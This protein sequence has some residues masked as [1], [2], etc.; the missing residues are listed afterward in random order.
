[1]A[2]TLA[3]LCMHYVI[4]KHSWRM[5]F[6]ASATRQM[7]QM[8]LS[9]RSMFISAGLSIL[10]MTTFIPDRG[11]STVCLRCFCRWFLTWKLISWK[12]ST[13]MLQWLLISY[14]I[15]PDGHSYMSITH[16]SKRSKEVC[17]VLDR[18]TPR[19][20]KDR[21][22]TGL[23]PLDSLSTPL[24]H[25]TSKWTMGFTTTV[26]VSYFV[27]RVWTGRTLSTILSLSASHVLM[28]SKI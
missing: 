1:M 4:S 16:C 14:V 9:R 3:T 18:T 13:R 17:P 7:S 21:Y 6:Y 8:K 25:A 24:L 12:V 11:V 2:A 27:L 23:S 28:L 15:H 5:A 22:S 19:A 26:Q 20:S 10:L